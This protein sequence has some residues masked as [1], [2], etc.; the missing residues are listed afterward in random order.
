M[1]G[2]SYETSRAN[3]N[4]SLDHRICPISNGGSHIEGFWVILHLPLYLKAAFFMK[5][6]SHQKEKVHSK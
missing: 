1:R 5:K 6:P 2:E 4:Q 3:E